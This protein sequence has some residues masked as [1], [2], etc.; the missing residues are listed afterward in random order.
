MLTTILFSDNFESGNLSTANWS[1]GISGNPVV[2]SENTTRGPIN[3]HG[4]YALNLDG[5]SL[6]EHEAV[7]SKTIDLRGY[8]WVRLEYAVEAG[9]QGNLPEGDD[10]LRIAYKTSPS[11]TSTTLRNEDVSQ[12]SSSSFTSRSLLLP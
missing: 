3:P 11:A 1:N 4:V 2:Q 6:T 5:G 12:V 8:S 7:N 10:D 9:G